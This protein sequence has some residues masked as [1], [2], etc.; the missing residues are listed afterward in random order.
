MLIALLT[1]KK[2]TPVSPRLMILSLLRVGTWINIY[3]G[4]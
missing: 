4:L 2:I 1:E 3:Y